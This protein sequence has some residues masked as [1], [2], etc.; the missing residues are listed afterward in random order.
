M[1]KVTDLTDIRHMKKVPTMEK[2]FPHNLIPVD[3]KKTK[4]IV[5]NG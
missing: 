2:V 5:V 3:A 4:N 1:V